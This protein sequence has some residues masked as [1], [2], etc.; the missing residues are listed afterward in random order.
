[1]HSPDQRFVAVKPAPLSCKRKPPACCESY[2]QNEPGKK[3]EQ[4]RSF[5]HRELST[6]PTFIARAFRIVD[7]KPLIG[8][9]PCTTDPKLSSFLDILVKQALRS[10]DPQTP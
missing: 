9:Y 5:A 10:V 3:K 7:V 1:V 2:G 4:N 6:S 8:K